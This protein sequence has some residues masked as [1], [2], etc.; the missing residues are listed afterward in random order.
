MDQVKI[1]ATLTFSSHN[2]LNCLNFFVV[3]RLVFPM[4]ARSFPLA[5][6]AIQEN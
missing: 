3:R 6:K 5:G 2:P 1:T 4:A